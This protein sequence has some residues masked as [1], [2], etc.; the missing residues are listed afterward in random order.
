MLQ[1]LAAAYFGGAVGALIV[2]AVLWISGRAELMKAIGVMYTPPLSW[3][4]IAPYLLGGSFF[5]L[6]YPFLR[7]RGLGPRRSGVILAILPCL[8]NLFYFLPHAGYGI[9]AIDLGAAAPLVVVAA[10]GI[11]GYALSQVTKR[12]GT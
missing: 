10:C 8:T 12:M 3:E 6:G 2:V 11:W 1:R 7:S 4:W 9:L 5:G